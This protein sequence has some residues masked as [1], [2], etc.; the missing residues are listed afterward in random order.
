[1]EED[2][3]QKEKQDNNQNDK[4]EKFEAFKQELTGIVPRKEGSEKLEFLKREEIRT[5]QK[6][7]KKLQEFEAEK[8]RDRIIATKPEIVEQKPIIEPEPSIAPEPE[9]PIKEEAES[10]P[11]PAAPE[12]GEPRLDE[13][14]R[15]PALEPELS[16]ELKPE[17]EP[18]PETIQEPEMPKQPEIKAE[19]KTVPAP[20]SKPETKEIEE[21][22]F[23]EV[24]LMPK[25]LRKSSP[26][27]KIL[28]RLSF[29][30][31][32][33][34]AILFGYWIFSINKSEEISQPTETET[35]TETEIIAPASLIISDQ[36]QTFE[37]S[38]DQEI[39][40]LVDTI[41]NQDIAAE[42]L[43][44]VIVKDKINNNF[45]SLQGMAQSLQISVPSNVLQNIEEDSLNTF[46]Y[47]QDQ[48]KRAVFVVKA[49]QTADLEQA[50]LEWET[51]IVQN[52]ISVSGKPV[53]F[54]TSPF[55]EF[56]RQA[57]PFKCIAVS[58]QDLGVCYTTFNG[59]LIITNSF[60]SIGNAIDRLMQEP[61][62][63]DKN[64][65]GQLFMVGF[66]GTL[67]TSKIRDFFKKYKPG[68]VLI[69]SR[70]VVSQQQLKSLIAELQQLSEQE[71]SLPLFVAVDQEGGPI[72]RI[73][74]LEEKTAQSDITTN[75][76]A[77]N[78]GFKK[79]QELQELGI[80]LNLAPMLD[81]MKSDDFYFNR[82]FQKLPSVAGELAKNM[83][84]GQKDAGILTSLKHFPGYVN[85]NFNPESKLATIPVPEISQFK[86]ANEAKPEMIMAA[87]ATYAG[88]DGILP[89]T[90]SEAGIKL[91]KDSL[92]VEPLIISDDL[93]QNSL[94]NNYNL[95]DILIKPVE[96][97]IDILIFSG[98]RNPVEQ[99]M[100]TFLEAVENKEISETR[101]NNAILRI[102]QLKTDSLK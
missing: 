40:G 15:E 80:N 37:I 102:T 38:D 52:G 63:V 44:R 89:L 48:G 78:I 8:E 74:F 2:K 90:F 68:G 96:A 93:A 20:I 57:T 31:L 87:N 64:K 22:E 94:L 95:K 3:E 5:M 24:G 26:L 98:W 16:S 54:I 17:P 91:L 88:I 9:L 76:Q 30:T 85:V 66:E 67:V 65:V 99:A 81:D 79:G 51:D 69:L 43:I 33:V 101:I 83:V 32:P 36:E 55:K 23:P 60:E 71:T 61:S 56:E 6:D 53:A 14:E 11:E 42:N 73:G 29:I 62:L 10:K 12:G 35:E 21:E 28:I 75:E 25:P 27:V 39:I 1:M 45:V 46:V 84:L 86:K 77:Y 7:I 19:D 92:G 59:L 97:G 41:L 13:S 49:K 50:L 34:L 47:S 100:D 72:S 18:T 82:A 4:D 58:L 70:N